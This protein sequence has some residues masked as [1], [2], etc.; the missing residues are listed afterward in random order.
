M[1]HDLSDPN[2]VTRPQVHANLEW[3]DELGLRFEALTRRLSRIKRCRRDSAHTGRPS[4][5]TDHG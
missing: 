3:L 1:I 2:R 4:K 5:E